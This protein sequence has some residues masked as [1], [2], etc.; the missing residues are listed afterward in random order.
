MNSV[1][2]ED[3]QEE[4]SSWWLKKGLK[5]RRD[6]HLFMTQILPWCLLCVR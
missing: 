3:F 1:E 4:V 6:V 5:L 2:F